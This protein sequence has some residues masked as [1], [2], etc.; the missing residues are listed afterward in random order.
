[1]CPHSWLVANTSSP[2]AQRRL[3]LSHLRHVCAGC[4]H[5]Q[6]QRR[7]AALG[8]Q[9]RGG[10]GSRR[11]TVLA[12]GACRRPRHLIRQ[13][14]L[15]QVEVN[16]GRAD[17]R[18]PPL[19]ELLAPAAGAGAAAA[20]Q[21][22]EGSF[23]GGPAFG[24]KAALRRSAA[25]YQ[26]GQQ[27]PHPSDHPAAPPARLGGWGNCLRRPRPRRLLCSPDQAARAAHAAG[28]ASPGAKA[29]HG[30]GLPRGLAVCWPQL[31]CARSLLSH[32]AAQRN[33]ESDG[34]GLVCNG[35]HPKKCLRTPVPR[36]GCP[37]RGVRTSTP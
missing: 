23:G 33:W 36:L 16:G 12:P 31:H 9:R 29:G 22:R 34:A 11:A 35:S 2:A 5:P 28:A 7:P 14:P 19:A 26:C 18:G 15:A 8:E 27:L 17:A 4:R 6:R 13:L 20:G 32:G 37:E 21:A 1:M 24:G 3:S 10:R 25:S 30:H